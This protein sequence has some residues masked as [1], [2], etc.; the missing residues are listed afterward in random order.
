MAERVRLLL[1]VTSADPG[2]QIRRDDAELYRLIS[3]VAEFGADH[4]EMIRVFRVM[5]ESARRI[6]DSQREFIDEVLL[7]PA[8]RD[9]M[10]ES[11]VL[12]STSARRLEYRDLGRQILDVVLDRVVDEAV[13]ESV[14]S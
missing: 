8:I 10:S 12:R 14:A 9:G 4:E 11:E 6:V 5:V 1:G 3:R 2:E 13:F 7:G